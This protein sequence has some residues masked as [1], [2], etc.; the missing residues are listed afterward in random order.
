MPRLAL[1][2]T[3]LL[4]ACAHAQPEGATP[5]TTAK[6]ATSCTAVLR[7]WDPGDHVRIAPT[8]P[9]PH[10]EP[11]TV[12]A[13]VRPDRGVVDAPWHPNIIGQRDHNGIYPPWVIGLGPELQLYTVVEGAWVYGETRLELER[14]AHLAVVFD[15]QEVRAYVDG[16]LDVQRSASSMGPPNDEA[17]FLGALGSGQQRYRGDIGAVRISSVARYRE[18]FVPARTWAPDAQTL[19][20]LPLDEGSGL[21][22]HDRSG[23]AQHGTLRGAR[24][25]RDCP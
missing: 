9:P 4:V 24:W 1:A 25:V 18:R 5:R 21:I 20:L 13:W 12:E 17:I 10:G 8:R 7:F 11:M 22:A 16:V 15:G 14:W 23:R 19:L 6:Q 3:T 2:L